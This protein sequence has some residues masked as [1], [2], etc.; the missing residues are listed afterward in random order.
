M[1][2]WMDGYAHARTHGARGLSGPGCAHGALRGHIPPAPPRAH[3]HP[4][5]PAGGR[6]AGSPDTPAGSLETGAHGCHSSPESAR[7]P[8]APVTGGSCARITRQ[9][10]SLAQRGRGGLGSRS[11]VWRRGPCA[12][13]APVPWNRPGLR[14]VCAESRGPPPPWLA[15]LG[16]VAPPSV[17]A[18]EPP[19]Q[20]PQRFRRPPV[21]HGDFVLEL[22]L[23]WLSLH[24]E[25]NIRFS[26]LTRLLLGRGALLTLGGCGAPAFGGL[27]APGLGRSCRVPGSAGCTAPLGQPCGTEL[28]LSPLAGITGL[29]TDVQA[30]TSPSAQVRMGALRLPVSGS[31]R[32]GKAPLQGCGSH[33]APCPASWVCGWHLL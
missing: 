24:R 33:T 22:L 28:S 31:W 30:V 10:D 25:K 3:L 19:A 29:L 18:V 6:S 8:K 23:R 27:E 13:R 5:P 20:L 17:R 12:R 9:L 21:C 7:Y 14:S 15:L 1:D 11:P 2:R 26:A 32:A 4:R 16:V